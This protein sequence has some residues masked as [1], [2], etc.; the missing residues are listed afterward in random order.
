MITVAFTDTCHYEF[1][2]RF[3]FWLTGW[4]QIIILYDIVHHFSN[5][6]YYDLSLHSQA[7]Y[8]L[9]QI[10]KHFHVLRFTS[11][12]IFSNSDWFELITWHVTVRGLVEC[13][14]LDGLL[15]TRR[16]KTSYVFLYNSWQ[17]NCIFWCSFATQQLGQI[18]EPWMPMSAPARVSPSCQASPCLHSFSLNRERAC[19]GWS[20]WTIGPM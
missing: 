9:I 1:I 19:V 11:T 17:I 15:K 4:L 20:P 12:L 14:R 8:W 16:P 10:W 2:L 5:S 18:D 13:A 3:N 6:H 7:K